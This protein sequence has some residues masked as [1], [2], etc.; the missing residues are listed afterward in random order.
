MVGL[1]LL[2]ERT[3]Q[4][5]LLG[6][7]SGIC[8]VVPAVHECLV[9]V[10][11]EGGSEMTSNIVNKASNPRTFKKKQISNFMDTFKTSRVVV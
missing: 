9:A 6:N 10:G 11:R 4:V 5:V 7:G 3:S 1:V 8:G 2:C